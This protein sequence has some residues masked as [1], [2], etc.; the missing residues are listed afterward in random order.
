[1]KKYSPPLISVVI[2]SYNRWSTLRLG[3]SKLRETRLPPET[4]EVIVSDSQ[5]EDD[6]LRELQQLKASWQ[7]L[8]VVVARNSG[9]A[10]ARN[11]GIYTASGKV[12]L[13]MDADMIPERGF[14]EKHLKF[15]RESN[16]SSKIAL[17]GLEVRVND[18]AELEEA[19][20]SV[21]RFLKRKPYRAS[22]KLSSMIPRI[23]PW[24]RTITGNLS[25]SRK[26]LIQAGLFDERFERYGYEDLEMGYRLSRLGVVL[27]HLRI[28]TFHL[29]P[30]TPLE[31]RRLGYVAGG[32]LAKFYL[33][34]N[35][36]SIPLSLGIN[37]FNKAIERLLGNWIERRIEALE[38]KRITDLKGF[39]RLLEDLHKQISTLKG[40]RDT[41]GGKKH[42]DSS[43]KD[44]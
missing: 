10:Q 30:Y 36:P 22:V 7:N 23:L 20:V 2:P 11:R 28:I 13:F 38:G 29:H 32:N 12:I 33:K 16:F 44:R 1:M 6:T 25:L 9:K 19:S 14:I 34:H 42:E 39:E 41:L 15:H 43:H 26:A 4:Y 18:L 3:L 24:Y 5:S 8:K 37:P 40:F 21:E 35:D 31:R 27:Y 17:L